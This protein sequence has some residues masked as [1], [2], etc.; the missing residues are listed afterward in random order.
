MWPWWGQSRVAAVWRELEGPEHGRR[1]REEG[2]EGPE[3]NGEHG[4]G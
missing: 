1:E 3:S 2:P 4:P